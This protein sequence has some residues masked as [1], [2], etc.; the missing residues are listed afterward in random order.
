MMGCERIYIASP[1]HKFLQYQSL[2]NARPLIIHNQENM[3][4]WLEIPIE[5]YLLAWVEACLGS[6]QN[7]VVSIRGAAQKRL[8]ST[9][10][11]RKIGYRYSIP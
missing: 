1:A 2:T 11:D 9:S 6:G 7:E 8:F 4:S 3:S 10:N 5:E